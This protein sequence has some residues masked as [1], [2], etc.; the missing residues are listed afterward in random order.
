[1]AFYPFFWRFKTKKGTQVWIGGFF[2]SAATLGGTWLWSHYMT[3][4]KDRPQ[5]LPEIEG[6]SGKWQ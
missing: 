4:H 3:H 1:M 5:D 2:L 6:R